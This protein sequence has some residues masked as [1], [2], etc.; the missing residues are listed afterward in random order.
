MTIPV[1][2]KPLLLCGIIAMHAIGGLVWAGDGDAGWRYPFWIACEENTSTR[3]A[4]FRKAFTLP[5][6]PTRCLVTVTVADWK[7][8]RTGAGYVIF[9]NGQ[10]VGER[11]ESGLTIW[12]RPQWHE[13]TAAAEAGENLVA[14]LVECKAK[15][16]NIAFNFEAD[17]SL[18]QGQRQMWR[19]DGTWKCFHSVPAEGSWRN[20]GFDD[21][22]WPY[23][24]E[25]GRKWGKPRA[26]SGGANTLPAPMEKISADAESQFQKMFDLQLKQRELNPVPR[27]RRLALLEGEM[28][29]REGNKALVRLVTA[30][31]NLVTHGTWSWLRK[32][33]DL[34]G[35]G[36]EVQ[37][38]N[39]QPEGRARLI[40]ASGRVTTSWLSDLLMQ[41]QV[42]IAHLP[43]EGYA[44]VPY[45]EKG[46]GFL[47]VGKDDTGLL[48]AVY[49][50]IQLL[51]KEGDKLLA[52]R[53]LIVDYP[54]MPLRGLIGYDWMDDL[55]WLSFY[56]FNRVFV[57]TNVADPI[58]PKFAEFTAL[59]RQMAIEPVFYIH[60]AVDF[61]FSNPAHIQLVFDQMDAAQRAGFKEVT[62]QCDDIPT[63]P[64]PQ[65][66]AAF[67]TGKLGLARAHLFFIEAAN[68]RT[69]ALG[70]RLYFCPLVYSPFGWPEQD[71]Y[72][73]IV[74]A[75]PIEVDMFTTTR[76]VEWQQRLKRP[77]PQFW[78]NELLDR[79][80]SGII[81]FS[82]YPKVP[83]EESSLL[84]G[85]WVMTH[86]FGYNRANTL[87]YVNN[88]WNLDSPLPLKA[89]L[90]RE[91][92]PQAAT[93]LHR[94]AETLGLRTQWSPEMNIYSAQRREPNENNL[95][96]ERQQAR[97]AAQAMQMDWTGSGVSEDVV[98]C[99][100]RSARKIELFHTLIA[101]WM[102]RNLT[103]SGA[104]RSSVGHSNE[105]QKRIDATIAD[106]KKMGISDYVLAKLRQKWE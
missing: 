14:V 89:A 33:L 71:E 34:S 83:Q 77:W 29:L 59:A 91:W 60:P 40:I 90:E 25:V 54:D 69:K 37:P 36:T 105:L 74:S 18:A 46:G 42:D 56:R 8:Y 16:G 51:R 106:L 81:W 21:S 24:R 88:W 67:G 28:L 3:A 52:R 15:D 53:A 11:S 20:K 9:L 1:K 95:R 47:L 6:K 17:V 87:C 99:L 13:A 94:Y 31:D 70:L 82:E 39:E 38:L 101:D 44:I 58:D 19:S 50:L 98:V 78:S 41:N 62:I 80:Y 35:L 102:E 2:V 27:P 103:K 23:A 12:E 93:Y 92:G 30:T 10:K 65:D 32:V 61:C 72:L 75:V 55:A 63:E 85:A 97:H 4:V 49:T 96:Y 79:T 66:A 22:Q 84:K 7:D 26:L 57:I 64:T 86:A 45:A 100:K 5:S 76:E 68:K 73:R 48:Y 43:D 104:I